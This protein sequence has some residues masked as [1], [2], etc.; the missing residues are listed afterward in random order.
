LRIERLRQFFE[1]NQIRRQALPEWAGLW[2][3][4][5]QTRNTGENWAEALE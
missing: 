2:T 4:S 3:M 1:W 5:A